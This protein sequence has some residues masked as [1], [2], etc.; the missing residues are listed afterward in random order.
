MKGS[1]SMKTPLAPVPPM[2]WNS[3]NTFGWNISDGLIRA[4]A[5]IFAES[6]LKD[7]GYEYIIIDD[8]WSESSRKNIINA[9]AF[10]FILWYYITAT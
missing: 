3:W 7:A 4:T 10:F 6:G 9:I 2:G 1:N 8:C 5:D